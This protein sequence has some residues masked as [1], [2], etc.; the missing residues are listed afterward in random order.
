MGILKSGFRG[1][2]VEY[3]HQ[4]RFLMR[5]CYMITAPMRVLSLNP[6]IG[7]GSP[8][9]GAHTASAC[10]LGG[11]FGSKSKGRVL[12]YVERYRHVSGDEC[13]SK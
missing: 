5:L 12:S 2:T 9:P 11:A 6:T 13:W 7:M 4:R 3:F 10:G 1:S 8:S